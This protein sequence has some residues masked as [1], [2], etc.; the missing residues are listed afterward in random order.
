[1]CLLTVIGYR[2][3]EP[4][5]HLSCSPRLWFNGGAALRI[6]QNIYNGFLSSRGG[7]CPHG[8]K[9][10]RGGTH[11]RVS[12]LPYV[13]LFDSSRLQS[14]F[15][16]G[17]T[18]GASFRH[19]F[20]LHVFSVLGGLGASLVIL[21]RFFFATLF[22]QT[23][24]SENDTSAKLMFTQQRYFFAA[25]DHPHCPG[26]GNKCRNGKMCLLSASSAPSF[27]HAARLYPSN[28]CRQRV[29]SPRKA[30]ETKRMWHYHPWCPDPSLVVGRRYAPRRALSLRENRRVAAYCRNCIGRKAYDL[31]IYRHRRLGL[32]H[33][34]I[35]TSRTLGQQV[36][37]CFGFRVT[38]SYAKK[39]AIVIL[40]SFLC[41]GMFAA[42]L[43]RRASQS[44]TA[45]IL[46]SAPTHPR[47]QRTGRPHLSHQAPLGGLSQSPEAF[48]LDS[49]SLRGRRK[50]RAYGKIWGFWYGL[51]RA[52]ARHIKVFPPT[53]MT[54][55]QVGAITEW[56]L[57]SDRLDG[58]CH[59][60]REAFGFA[61]ST[62]MF[63]PFALLAFAYLAIAGR[64]AQATFTWRDITYL[65]ETGG[66]TWA[67]D[68][69]FGEVVEKYVCNIGEVSNEVDGGEVNFH[70]SRIRGKPEIVPM[71]AA[72][73]VSSLKNCNAG[74]LTDTT[75]LSWNLLLMSKGDW[76][77]ARQGW[78][79]FDDI[80]S[81]KDARNRPLLNPP[82]AN[83]EPRHS[84]TKCLVLWLP[85]MRKPDTRRYI[86][87]QVSSPS[88]GHC[89][90]SIPRLF[91]ELTTELD[92]T[93]SCSASAAKRYA[94]MKTNT[95]LCL[96]PE[97]RT[98]AAVRLQKSPLSL[99]SFGKHGMNTVF[100]FRPKKG[101]YFNTATTDTNSEWVSR[102]C[103]EVKFA[104]SPAH[105]I[106]RPL[107]PFFASSFHHRK[108]KD[109]AEILGVAGSSHRDS[110][111]QQV[112]D[113]CH[114]PGLAIARP[115][116]SRSQ[117]RPQPEPKLVDAVPRRTASD[118]VVQQ[119]PWCF[120]GDT[121]LGLPSHC[122]VGGTRHVPWGERSC[123]FLGTV[124][125]DVVTRQGGNRDDI[126][127]REGPYGR[128][129]SSDTV[130][131]VVQV[132]PGF[133][134]LRTADS[135]F[136]SAVTRRSFTDRD[137][138]A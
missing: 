80:H 2:P 48:M 113:Q 20:R 37:P 32:D 112:V 56:G 96:G 59:F 1:M 19:Y 115:D 51:G 55:R 65:A 58:Y 134:L 62:Q 5:D 122:A 131:Q 129:G 53:T 24:Q 77:I 50:S 124:V 12:H 44:E 111:V 118:G 35:I 4:L 57:I 11:T 16:N 21:V 117:R 64:D 90:Y 82:P 72:A 116:K 98:Q 23:A 47:R 14:T 29:V 67:D 109:H 45:A 120:H 88:D 105:S 110:R 10:C 130:G 114:E 39:F 119:D 8:L 76:H 42:G 106:N 73:S 83:D 138:H 128:R 7:A 104:V 43:R 92:T 27:P 54:F 61:Q 99:C 34:G 101:T 26:Q 40:N 63:G 60:L 18:P 66:Q 93:C 22:A 121:I 87:S 25:S 38:V 78:W 9:R 86:N 91:D 97:R 79:V 15:G 94:K 85:L 71:I 69:T 6:T 127:A 123:L 100:R 125:Q 126:S 132:L 31:A 102:L 13:C 75:S 49:L 107:T 137:S 52:A 30:G 135:G 133:H 136:G 95:I 81:D 70:N 28:G 103:D 108:A 36:A 84:I 74:W 46:K 33:E 3:A 17:K 89:T 68:I 41:L